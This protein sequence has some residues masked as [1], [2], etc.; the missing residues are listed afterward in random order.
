MLTMCSES[1]LNLIPISKDSSSPLDYTFNPS[2][3]IQ[4]PGGHGE[5]LVRDI[6]TDVSVSQ[7]SISMVHLS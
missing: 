5:E 6:V 2:K 3:S 7:S 4:L 1:S